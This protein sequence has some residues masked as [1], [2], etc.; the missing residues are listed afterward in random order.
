MNILSTRTRRGAAILFSGVL[1]LGGLTLAGEATAGEEVE[2]NPTCSGLGYTYGEKWDNEPSAGTYTL[3]RDGMDASLTVG[4]YPDKAEP[5]KNNAIV[6][7]SISTMTDDHAIVV[8]GGDGATVYRSVPNGLESPP[9]HAPAVSSGKWPTISHFQLCWNAAPVSGEL[10]V[11][12]VV[13][14]TDT[15]DDYEFE[16][17]V[18]RVPGGDPLCKKVVGEGTVT[19]EDLRPGDYVVTETDPGPRFSVAGSG[20][21]VTVPSEDTATA[22]V[23]N[24]WI[25][26]GEEFGRVEVTKVVDGDGAPADDTY[27]ICL[28]GP[29]PSTTEICK[30]VVGEG[31]VTFDDLV[32]GRYAVTETDPGENYAVAIHPRH[33]RCD[34]RRAGEGH[35]DEHLHGAGVV[36]S[37]GS[38]DSGRS[39][40]PG[41]ADDADRADGCPGNGGGAR[42]CHPGGS[43]DSAAHNGERGRD[44]R[45]RCTPR[46]HGC[47]AH[48]AGP[49]SRTTGLT[50]RQ[51]T[52]P[53]N[54]SPEWRGGPPGPPLRRDPSPVNRWRRRV[55][56]GREAPDPVDSNPC[57]NVAD[58]WRA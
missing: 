8:K 44:R 22:T 27:R 12:K 47:R 25:P 31:T 33:R 50:D 45:H 24:T 53:R 49:A 30:T 56:L 52:R 36:A 3:D 14:G 17:C 5:N 21:T 26:S 1:V 55:R 18:S 34:D 57:P 48:L 10:E 2:G 28:T 13:L 39:R 23:T 29:D 7:Y 43:P 9:L 20:I 35:R 19:F 16:I 38:R 37:P 4:T 41:D 51:H 15:P 58:R 40:D 6:G 11:T 42:D 32:P 46:R 54:G